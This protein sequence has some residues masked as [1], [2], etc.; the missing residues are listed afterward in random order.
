MLMVRCQKMLRCR[1]DQRKRNIAAPP[2]GSLD[3]PKLR[4]CRYGA[5]RPGLSHRA[6]SGKSAD[7]VSGLPEICDQCRPSRPQPTWVVVVFR[8]KYEPLKKLERIPI[9]PDR[10]AV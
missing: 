7:L 8:R 9:Q 1:A 4:Q 6:F 10:I 3:A 2:R 5:S